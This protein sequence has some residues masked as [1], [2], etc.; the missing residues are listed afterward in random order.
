VGLQ[1]STKRFAAYAA[2][3]VFWGASFL[4]IREIVSVVPPFLA[5]GIRMFAAG[6]LLLLYSWFARL[7]LPE[8]RQIGSTAFLGLIMF[9][10][11]YA[12]LFWAEQRVASGYAAIISSTIPVWVF[13]GEW[14]WLR[15][16]HPRG[17]AIAGMLLGVC[18]V[19]LLVLPGGKGE[20]TWPALAILA[21]TFCWASGTLFSRRL[22]MPVS[23]HISAGLQMA[24]GG[25]FLLLLAAMTGELASIP[26][27]LSQWN[28]RLTLDM[29][30]LIFIASIAAFLAYVWLIDHEPAS[31][32][33]SYAYVNPLIATSLG[34]VVA[35]ERLAPV[36][37]AGAGLVLTGVAI[38]LRA[39]RT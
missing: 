34:A 5:A 39:R 23:R 17:S 3:F 22:P 1:V 13:A 27:F 38:T 19:T 16:I 9:G 20:W 8:M 18:G 35:G 30:Y 28:V 32:V 4:A 14:L 37:L 7:P 29:A 24:F 12:C 25:L 15:A 11:N 10:I 21:G 6:G 36:Q 2:I 31:R 33:S 26:V